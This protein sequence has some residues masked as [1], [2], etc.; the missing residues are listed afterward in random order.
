VFCGVQTGT[1]TSFF[2]PV[3]EFFPFDIN[4][5]SSTLIFTTVI[6]LAEGQ[7]AKHANF[8]KG[9]IYLSKNW[10]HSVGS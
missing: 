10:K 3:I 8:K 5:R 7:M 1:G 4:H 2:S 9:A 6:Y